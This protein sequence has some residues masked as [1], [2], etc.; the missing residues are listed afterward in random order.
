M[1]PFSLCLLL[2]SIKNSAIIS[3]ARCDRF[4]FQAACFF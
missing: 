3:A 4:I 2:H 1:D